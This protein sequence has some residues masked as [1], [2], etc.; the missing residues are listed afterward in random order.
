MLQQ[1]KIRTTAG[2]GRLFDSILDTVGDTPVIRINNLGPAHATIYVKAEFFNPAASVKDRL[3][4]NIIEEGERSGKLKP[5]QTVV[6]ATSGNTGIGLAMVCAQKGYPLVVTMADS[7]S[8]ERRKLMRMLGAKVVLTPRAQKGFGMYKKAVELA[9]ANGWFLARQ[10]ETE[11]NA[12]IHEA[13]TAREIINDFAGSRLDVL[14]T[15]YGTGGT[16]A[17]VGRVL[18]RE[19]PD[20]RIVLAEPANAQLIGSGKTQERGAG[21]APAASHPAFEPHPIQGWTPDFIPNVLQEAIDQRYYDEVVPIPGPEGIK[22]AK[23]LAQQEGIF[24]GISGGATFAV[25]RQIAGTAPAGSVILCMLPDTGERYMSTPLF[26]G[27]EAEMDADEMALSRST[28][29]CQFDA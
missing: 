23:A 20:V 11:A 19:R 29:S 22:W 4:L 21:G 5:G 25:A 7:F 17:G 13:T 14:V 3:A 16:I 12:A 15:G 2:R 9:E 6:E 24:T 18:R 26:D 8:I 10:F 28:P 1:L 27:I